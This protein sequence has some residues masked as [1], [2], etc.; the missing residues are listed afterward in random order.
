VLGVLRD[1]ETE[2]WFTERQA[3][4]VRLNTGGD[5]FLPVPA[6]YE[7]T[8]RY[9]TNR[10]LGFFAEHDELYWNAIGTDW[11]F[12]IEEASV[13]VRL[14][15]AV[16]MEE[17]SAEGYTGP[18]GAQ[19]SAYV[20]DV[21]GPGE[22]RYRLTEPLQPREGFTIVLTFPKGLIAEPSRAQRGRWLLFDNR[23]VLLALAGL[24]GL[25]VYSGRKWHLVGR[26]PRPGI[27]IPRYRPPEGQSPAALR[28]VRRMGYDMRCFSSDVLALAVGGHVRVDR[29]ERRLRKDEWA[30]ERVAAPGPGASTQ[31]A[32]F[33][34]LFV[35]SKQRIELKDTNASTIS[36]AR[37][38]HQKALEAQTH[39]R[40]FKRNTAH[41]VVALVIAAVSG[42]GA[43]MIS[44]GY[45]IPVIMGLM[46]VMA[47]VVVVFANLVRAPTAEGRALLDEIEGLK[48]YLS[49]A[50]KDDLARLKGPTGAG[51]SPGPP[52]PL[53]AERFEALLPYAVALEVEDAGSRKFTAAV[54]AAAAAAATAGMTW[55][56]G[57]GPVTDIGSFTRAV[58]S[59]L[60]STISSSSSPPGSS[61]GSGGGGSSGGG[62]GGGGG[63]G[64]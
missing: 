40:Y 48:L 30:L 60:N 27:I 19:G 22:A 54:G 3:N 28:F 64:R 41:W 16:P 13:V 1:G 58:G 26:D 2:D 24:L 63:G 8:L 10:Q 35:G 53:D 5:D 31:G 14:P 25:L 4:G 15:S 37:A 42:V 59:S 12:M 38:A 34:R 32:L 55:Y 46:A 9:R 51:T 36:A 29:N 45:G 20:A 47:V 33:G 23:G 49:V 21:V 18:Q 61:S 43:L 7:F 52:P 44:G 57:R 50:E 6:E 17:M 11:A 39:P 62:G 56:R